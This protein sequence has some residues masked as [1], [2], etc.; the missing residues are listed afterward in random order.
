[1]PS[2]KQLIENLEYANKNLKKQVSDLTA[3]LNSQPSPS[4]PNK[5]TASKEVA[6]SVCQVFESFDED[7]YLES[8]PDL[9]STNVNPY[10]HF[11][12]FGFKEGRAFAPKLNDNLLK[13][14]FSSYN[15]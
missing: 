1:M 8:N 10:E 11:I 14:I 7:F 15:D 2:E 9:R 3:K 6:T 4:Q 13:V 12:K 5:V